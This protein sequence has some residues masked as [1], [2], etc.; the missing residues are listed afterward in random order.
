MNGI[1]P[2]SL[3]IE[4]EQTELV[5]NFEKVEERSDGKY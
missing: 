2:E 5:Q 1:R 4:A 3:N